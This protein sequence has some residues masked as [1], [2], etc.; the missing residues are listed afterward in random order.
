VIPSRLRNTWHPENFHLH[1]RLRSG[2]GY[3]EG[4]YFKLVDAGGRQPYAI[5]PGVYLG[6]DS[7]AFV[8]ILDGRAGTAAYHRFPIESF[9]A[10]RRDFCVSIA[11]SRFGTEGLSLNIAGDETSAKQVIRGELRLG[12]FRRWPVRFHSPG[13][14]GPYSFVPFMECKHGILSLD[15]TVNGRLEVDGRETNF[16]GGRGYVEKDWGRAFPSGYVWTQSNHFER[17]GISLTA[18]VA[19]IPWLTGSFRGFLVGFLIDGELHRF[20]TY[21]GTT[22]ESL[23]RSETHLHLCVR[24]A[25]HRLEIDARKTEGA[26]LHAPYGKQMIER[27]SETMTSDIDLRLTSVDTGSC[28]YEGRGHHACLEAQGDL[29]A[30]LDA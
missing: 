19:R 6:A 14:M 24:N 9:Y 2:G 27:V 16:D 21:N 13:V 8:Q 20:T 1:H 3:F 15:H 5:I 23:T 29:D 4:W 11:G 17:P 7:H 18:S 30:V 12:P 28:V 26:V 10:D 25:T 22:I